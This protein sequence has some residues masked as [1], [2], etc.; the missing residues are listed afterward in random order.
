MR[1]DAGRLY[2]AAR[3]HVAPT[4][5]RRHAEDDAYVVER[6]FTPISEVATATNVLD[7]FAHGEREA[8]CARADRAPGEER[9]AS[10]QLLHPAATAPLFTCNRS[11]SARWR[12]QP[13]H[14][15]YRGNG[16][17]AIGFDQRQTRPMLTRWYQRCR[18]SKGGRNQ[19]AGG[20][21]GDADT[22][23]AERA[24]GD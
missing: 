14:V 23:A 24:D 18:A 16:A 8:T 13:D 2:A 6:D 11:C 22:A 12:A 15:P 9:A 3:H 5:S 21:V 19:S 17:L 1:G 20:Y 7:R 10:A 4:R